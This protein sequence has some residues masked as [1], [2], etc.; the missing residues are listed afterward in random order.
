MGGAA[1]G[2]CWAGVVSPEI[3]AAVVRTHVRVLGV[4]LVHS[5]EGTAPARGGNQCAAAARVFHGDVVAAGLAWVVT[6]MDGAIGL[7]G[8]ALEQV[9][10][11]LHGRV[12]ILGYGVAADE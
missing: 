12:V 6:Q 5:V 11:L 1:P 9:G 3:A 8:D 7:L 2:P 10:D 4:T